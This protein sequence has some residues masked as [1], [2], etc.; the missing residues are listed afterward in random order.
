MKFHQDLEALHRRLTDELKK[1]RD[2]E[3]MLTKDL[4]KAKA[5]LLRSQNHLEK[6]KKERRELEK[7]LDHDFA[8]ENKALYLELDRLNGDLVLWKERQETTQN[9]KEK[10]EE[11]LRGISSR[12]ESLRKELVTATQ[13][14]AHT[15]HNLRESEKVRLGLEKHLRDLSQ[16][17]QALYQE[18]DQVNAS[19]E[20]LVGK[21]SEVKLYR[22]P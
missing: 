17:K 21:K 12:E 19:L 7:L 1:T 4:D 11:N 15:R 8:K 3:K 13:D 16:E 5:T 20:G 18:L 10:V 6:A 14:L 2:S 22:S 9:A